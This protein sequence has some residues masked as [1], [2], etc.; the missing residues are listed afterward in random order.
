M[1]PRK[2]PPTYSQTTLPAISSVIE[3]EEE[4]D[5][6]LRGPMPGMHKNAK[7]DD[8]RHKNDAIASKPLQ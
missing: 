3:E 5:A 8:R 7:I 2:P 4:E 6:K 1:R